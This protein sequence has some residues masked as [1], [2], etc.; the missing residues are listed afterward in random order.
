MPVEQLRRR[1]AGPPG[2]SSRTGSR[3]CGSRPCAGSSGS[4]AGLP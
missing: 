3:S 2:Q 1:S 4:S